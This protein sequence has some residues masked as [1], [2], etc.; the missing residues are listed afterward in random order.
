MDGRGWGW[1]V[2]YMVAVWEVVYSIYLAYT[3]VFHPNLRIVK[4]T[5]MHADVF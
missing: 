2:M 5:A 3:G 1:L 4:Y